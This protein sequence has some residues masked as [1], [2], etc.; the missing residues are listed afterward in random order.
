VPSE[1]V[2]TYK[3]S[4]YWSGYASDILPIT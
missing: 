2:N 3:S 1:S 4:E